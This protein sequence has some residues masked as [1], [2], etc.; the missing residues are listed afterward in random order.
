MSVIID[1]C[2]MKN[3]RICHDPVSQYLPAQSETR[4]AFA[5]AKEFNGIKHQPQSGGNMTISEKNRN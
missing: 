5:A 1:V 2:V 3:C 4:L